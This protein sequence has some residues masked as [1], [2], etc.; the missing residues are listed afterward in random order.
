MHGFTLGTE[1][2]IK[3][4]SKVFG[5]LEVGLNPRF[6]EFPFNLSEFET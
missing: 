5:P 2:R 6:G 3:V 1:A 4:K